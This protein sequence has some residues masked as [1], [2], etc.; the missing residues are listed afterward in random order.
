MINSFWDA[1]R[2]R[3]APRHPTEQVKFSDLE[4]VKQGRPFRLGLRGFYLGI[5]PFTA[6]IINGS[7]GSPRLYT[8]GS[9]IV[10]TQDT[11]QVRYVDLNQRSTYLPNVQ[12]ESNDAW[13]VSLTISLSWRV[14][15]ALQIAA[16]AD[17]LRLLRNLTQAAAINTIAIYPHDGL[18]PTP[19]VKPIAEAEIAERILNQLRANPALA[20]FD[21]ISVN[22]LDR[23]GDNRR[24]EKI[25][26]SLIDLTENRQQ[27]MLEIER[28]NAEIQITKQKLEVLKQQAELVSQE[29]A[30]DRRRVE[31]QGITDLSQ[32]EA[33]ARIAAAQE[34]LLRQLVDFQRQLA[35]QDLE[36]AQFMK[37]LEV[38][39]EAFKKMAEVI[40]QAQMSPGF[41]HNLDPRLFEMLAKSM[42]SL[43]SAAPKIISISEGKPPDPPDVLPAVNIKN[44]GS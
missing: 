33:Q 14:R 30:V 2:S 34:P 20:G 19:Q 44:L 1:M 4:L 23:H 26:E 36:Q 42:E 7:D 13:K 43:A 12:A 37:I 39:G 17:P 32:A 27:L 9:L 6:A 16:T 31:E 18:V 3:L 22:V 15:N 25:Q 5:P 10:G 8:R 38:S 28:L 24:T 21:F 11:Y 35:A 41:Q 29:A 40:I